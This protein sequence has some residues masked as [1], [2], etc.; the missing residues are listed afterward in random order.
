MFGIRRS[1]EPVDTSGVNDPHIFQTLVEIGLG[2]C[3]GSFPKQTFQLRMFELPVHVVFEMTEAVR[4]GRVGKQAIN[5]FDE[6]F[7]P[8]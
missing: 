7:L 5:S 4:V 6:A 2:E 1:K 8:I 3:P